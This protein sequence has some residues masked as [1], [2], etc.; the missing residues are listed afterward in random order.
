MCERELGNIDSISILG[1][2]SE[3]LDGL[4][5]VAAYRQSGQH[6]E[7]SIPDSKLQ[8]KLIPVTLAWVF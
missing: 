4:L 2:E 3:Y 7:A 6:F 1:F 5:E 8:P